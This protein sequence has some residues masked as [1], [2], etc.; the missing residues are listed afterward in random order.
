MGTRRSNAA[1]GW[2][3]CS[4]SATGAPHE[5]AIDFWHTTAKP[6]QAAP[7]PPTPKPLPGALG[8]HEWFGLAV[9]LPR[10]GRYPA[11]CSPAAMPPI[12]VLT[13]RLS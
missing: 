9:E 2:A 11:V 3:D 6:C 13:M 7:R 4:T 12:V 10:Y 8:P 5:P 1:S